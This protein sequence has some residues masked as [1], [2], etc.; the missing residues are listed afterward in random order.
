M[1]NL[2]KKI[3]WN[4][5]VIIAVFFLFDFLIF[6]FDTRKALNFNLKKTYNLYKEF[7]SN[8]STNKVLFDNYILDKNNFYRKTINQNSPKKPILLFGCSFTY[9][10]K[11]PEDKIF[12]EVLGKYTKR[13]VYNRAMHGFGVQQMLFQLE[14]KEFYNIIPQPEYIIYTYIGDHIRRMYLPSVIFVREYYDI[15]YKNKNGILIRCQNNKFNKKTILI[16]AIEDFL[17]EKELYHSNLK[18][19]EILLKNHLLAAKKY[20]DINWPGTKFVIFAYLDTKELDDISGE[21]KNAGFI[22]VNRKDIAPF[23]DFDT[24]FCL[25]NTDVHPNEHAWEYIVPRLTEVLGID[26]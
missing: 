2:S 9:G 8:N 12:S 11:I 10:H 25:S 16:N 6:Y 17:Y 5:T 1:K 7:Y 21:L 4:L 14:N 22:I 15:K 3:F 18:E 26:L 20:V 24:G 19:K 13:P 23:D